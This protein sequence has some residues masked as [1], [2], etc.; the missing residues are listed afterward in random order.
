MSGKDIETPD[1][2]K[3]DNLKISLKDSIQEHNLER[4]HV[5]HTDFVSI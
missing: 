1:V 3:S 2:D 5:S 4:D